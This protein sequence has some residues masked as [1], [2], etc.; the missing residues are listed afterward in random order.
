[1]LDQTLMLNG[2]AGEETLGAA[3]KWHS[4]RDAITAEFRPTAKLITSESK[5]VAL[6]KQLT[7]G[8]AMRSA[9]PTLTSAVSEPTGELDPVGQANA[10][11][12]AYER[13][14]TV[15]TVELA[16]VIEA[17]G[18]P[19]TIEVLKPSGV[20]AFDDAAISAVRRALRERQRAE[21]DGHA[22]GLPPARVVARMRVSAGRAVE[23]PHLVPAREPTANNARH[24]VRGLLGGF[25]GQFDE[26]SRYA[27]ADRPLGD[28]VSTQVELISVT[29]APPEA[30]APGPVSPAAPRTAQ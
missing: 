10:A 28:I 16:V 30:T 14:A 2:A 25:T 11:R 1:M 12:Q 8:A 3:G 20:S 6:V 13:P 27:R 5:P 18:Q 17:D 15:R 7:Q 24:P 22:D 19:S 4:V 21:P 9:P 29:P 23:L 26:T